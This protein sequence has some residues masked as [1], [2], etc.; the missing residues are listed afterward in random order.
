MDKATP[1]Y[2][3]AEILAQMDCVDSMNLKLSTL[4]DLRDLRLTRVTALA[5]VRSLT[6][7]DFYKSM[8]SQINP[9]T[10]QDVYRPNYQGKALYLKFGKVIDGEEFQ[11]V[12]CKEK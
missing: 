12:S 1:H 8:E 4:D 2:P 7:T 5:I 3:L 11:V 10:W 6:A 9:D